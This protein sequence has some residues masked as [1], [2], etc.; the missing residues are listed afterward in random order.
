MEVGMTQPPTLHVCGQLANFTN[1]L[2]DCQL[3]SRVPIDSR[4]WL[5]AIGQIYKRASKLS[6]GQTRLS[7]LEEGFTFNWPVTEEH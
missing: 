2:V 6:A 4:G 7:R 3:G 5:T 1:A